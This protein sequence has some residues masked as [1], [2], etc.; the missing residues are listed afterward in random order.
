MIQ[1][2]RRIP[3][4]GKAEV[5]GYEVSLHARDE[6]TLDG[7]IPLTFVFMLVTVVG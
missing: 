1:L 2:A 7:D 3:E 6:N 5:G 4:C